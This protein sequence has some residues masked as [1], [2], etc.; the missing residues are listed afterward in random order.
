MLIAGG[1]CAAGGLIAW[2]RT[3]LVKAMRSFA[4]AG[5]ESADERAERGPVRLGWG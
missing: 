1:T 3:G 4:I 5:G 2:A